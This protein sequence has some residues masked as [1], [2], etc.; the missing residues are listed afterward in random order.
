M[1]RFYP[2][3][4]IG[5]IG[6]IKLKYSACCCLCFVSSRRWEVG[7]ELQL[8]RGEEVGLVGAALVQTHPS[9]NV[10]GVC[11]GP[12]DS[13]CVAGARV[14]PGRVPSAGSP[15]VG[16]A[17]GPRVDSVSGHA[18]GPARVVPPHRSLEPPQAQKRSLQTSEVRCS[19]PDFHR[20]KSGVKR[21]GLL[22]RT[23]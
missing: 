13:E 17:S 5:H 21:A 16:A 14:P 3:V 11:T 2:D 18:A 20:R 6:Q 10:A 22:I 12:R 15:G 19:S 8:S 4:G 9:W 1:R 23:V 7:L